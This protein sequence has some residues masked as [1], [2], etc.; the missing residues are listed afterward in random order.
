MAGKEKAARSRIR[1]AF[2]Y[3]IIKVTRR[4]AGNNL[5]KRKNAM[6]GSGHQSLTAGENQWI[7]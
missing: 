3:S 2:F 4:I 6:E 1:H 5:R 7:K